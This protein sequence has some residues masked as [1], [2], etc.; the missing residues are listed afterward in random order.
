MTTNHVNL[1]D[2]FCSPDLDSDSECSQNS[3]Q[4]VRSEKTLLEKLEILTNQ[5]LIQVV[6]IFVDWLRANTDIILMCAQVRNPLA[7]SCLWSTDIFLTELNKPLI[8]AEFSEL[9]ESSVCVA[10][11]PPRW[12]KVT[13]VRSV[14]LWLWILLL[15][16]VLQKRKHWREKSQRLLSHG[17]FLFTLL[18]F[19]D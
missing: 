8:S 7:F 17:S 1:D 9:V 18:H 15:A 5:G 16:S 14:N 4:S 2:F 6:K 12:Q 13:G 3:C 10:Q 11:P 19:Q